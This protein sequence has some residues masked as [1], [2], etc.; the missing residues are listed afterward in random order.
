MVKE[1]LII[2]AFSGIAWAVDPN[3][4]EQEWNKF[5]KAIHHVETS[6]KGIGTVGD[7]GEAYGP[8]Q[9]HKG[10]FLDSGVA[11]EWESC[12]NDLELSRK[13]LRGYIKRYLPKNGTMEMAACIWNAGPVKGEFKKSKKWKATEEYRRKFRKVAG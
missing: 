9:I 11:G 4:T 13:V 5:E 8:L 10:A 3:W 1:F 2:G 6:G 7:S 12:L